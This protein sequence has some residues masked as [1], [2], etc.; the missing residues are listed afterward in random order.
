MSR[1]ETEEEQIE[2][3]KSWW[4]KNGTQLLTAVLV[5]V[6]AISGWRYWNHHQAVKAT[7]ASAIF[8][9]LQANM[10][11][12]TFGEVSREGLKLIQEQP[13]SPY[14]S[15][16]ALLLAKFSLDKGDLDDAKQQLEWV[17]TQGADEALK[18][19]AT[20]RLARLLA[21]QKDYSQAQETLNS[22]SA[23]Q[24]PVAEKANF[25]Y[26]SGL[27]ALGQED[28][29][30]ARQAFSKVVENTDASKTLKGIAQIQLDDLAA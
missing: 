9:V 23:K 18:Q 28:K 16:A 25:D 4:K 29:E 11:Q 15:G 20:L 21:D 24:L 7:N 19:V 8:E 13:E 22:I 3:I 10:Q 5:V 17:R 26:V 27:I 2:A 14:A 30:A 12:G 6:V 1:Y